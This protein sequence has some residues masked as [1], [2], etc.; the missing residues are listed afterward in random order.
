MHGYTAISAENA[1]ALVYHISEWQLL[2]HGY[3]NISEDG[4]QQWYGKRGA[5]WIRLKHRESA[6]TIF[7]VNH[8]GPLPVGSG[9]MCGGRA[10]A[11]SMLKIIADHAN[12]DDLVV[13]AGDFN[14]HTNSPTVNELEKRMFRSF[15]GSA[16][17]GIDHFFSN[18]GEDKLVA[19][20]DLGPGG[21][22]HNAL[23][24]VFRI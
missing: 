9:G 12:Q 18:C 3:Q 15:T 1:L 14:A 10:A 21:S 8:H 20:Q 4:Q 11:Y 22:D 5:Q 7:V 24:V 23:S 2:K 6:K 17:G 13:L 16:L 19:T